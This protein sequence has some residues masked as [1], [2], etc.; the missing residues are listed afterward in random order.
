M[1]FLLN[2]RELDERL[3]MLLSDAATDLLLTAEL[4]R[5]LPKYYNSD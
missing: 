2:K 1:R 4:G 5:D 3:L